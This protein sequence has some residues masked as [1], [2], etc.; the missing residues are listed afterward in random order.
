MK[1]TYYKHHY[2]SMVSY[3]LTS[4][5]IDIFVGHFY[6]LQVWVLYIYLYYLFYSIL[7]CFIKYLMDFKYK[8]FWS[9]LLS[10]GL[11]NICLFIFYHSIVLIYQNFK[12]NLNLIDELISYFNNEN[13]KKFIIIRSLAEFLFFGIYSPII[14]FSFL[15]EFT[16]NHLL[17]GSGLSN[18]IFNYVIFLI[19][20]KN[21]YNIFI[22][23]IF[24]L[25]IFNLLVYLEII[26]IN[27]CGMDRNTK[28][29]ILFREQSENFNEEDDIIDNNI[30]L[31]SG[32]VF[33]EDKEED[34]ITI[35]TNEKEIDEIEEKEEKES[36]EVN[37][38]NI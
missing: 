35:K 14:R 30:E 23:T 19:G 26:E 38:H 11:C 20:N 6:R 34:D 24:G 22:G 17:I 31:S 15:K 18:L 3:T 37:E 28:K 2:L 1:Y 7:I 10:I 5:L 33:K 13:N 8:H 25:Q 21:L 29:N 9:I 12:G 27:Y 32:Y 36:K 16:P 4:I